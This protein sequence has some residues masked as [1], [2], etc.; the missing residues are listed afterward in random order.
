MLL[1]IYQP[2]DV[3]ELVMKISLL[4]G[5]QGGFP[6]SGLRAGVRVR[7]YVCARQPCARSR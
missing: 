2:S 4:A 5:K 1:R 3:L 7:V 6:Q